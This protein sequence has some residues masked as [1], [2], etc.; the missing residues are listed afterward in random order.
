M[1]FVPDLFND[2][3]IALQLKNTNKKNDFDPYLKLPKGKVN[4]NNIEECMKSSIYIAYIPSSSIKQM[5][6][7]KDL[8]KGNAAYQVLE[9]CSKFN[10]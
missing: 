5:F 1:P 7:N 3:I 6:R 4:E 10:Y 9:T 2:K 8:P